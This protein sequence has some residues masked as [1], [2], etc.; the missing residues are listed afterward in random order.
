MTENEPKNDLFEKRIIKSI[1]TV[2]DYINYFEDKETGIIQL[3]L[4]ALRFIDSKSL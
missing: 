3:K 4:D 2:D 1:F